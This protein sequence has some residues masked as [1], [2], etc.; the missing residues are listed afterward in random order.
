VA[1][2]IAVIA[3]FCLTVWILWKLFGDKLV[4]TIVDAL[5]EDDPT[6]E[7]EAMLKQLVNLQEKL[8]DIKDMEGE[9]Y[10]EE[11]VRLRHLIHTLERRIEQLVE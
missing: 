10:D 9:I 11:R 2:A 5:S 8:E 6:L 1:S 4:N 7:A 3:I